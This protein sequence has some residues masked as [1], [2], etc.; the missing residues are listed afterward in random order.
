MCN[1][2]ILNG[3]YTS[4]AWPQRVALKPTSKVIVKEK[5]IPK[6]PFL[7]TRSTWKADWTA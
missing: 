1:S 3:Q 7:I 2:L 5:C 6:K 4:I